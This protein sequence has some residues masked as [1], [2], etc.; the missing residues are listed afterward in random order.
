M[1][2][3][4]VSFLSIAAFKKAIGATK[5]E[6]VHNAKTGKLSML[7]DDQSFYRCQQAIDTSEKMSVLIAD[8]DL[9]RA[10]LV[11][12]SSENSPLSVQASL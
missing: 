8:G 1:A 12:T 3:T 4:N 5:L 7:A 9:D 6:V 10:C 11:N 2:D